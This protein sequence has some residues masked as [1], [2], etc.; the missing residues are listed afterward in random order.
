MTE[1]SEESN[2]VP[3]NNQSSMSHGPVP[4]VTGGERHPEVEDELR[5]WYALSETERFQLL[6]ESMERRRVFS[7][8]ALV[9]ICRQMF[10]SGDRKALNFAFEALSKEAT[11]LLLSQAWGLARDERHEQVQEILLH[12]FEKIQI[13]KADFAEINFAA[14]SRRKAISLYRKKKTRFEGANQ[15]IERTDEFD[16]L[17]NL[18]A[19]LP[20]PEVQALLAHSLNKLSPKHQEVFIQYHELR[21]TQKEISEHH[22]VTVR[23]VYNWL[24]SANAAIGL[25]GGNDDC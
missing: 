3:V 10:A 13:N 4:A 9:H 14:F 2:G 11:P 23:S 18:P 24:K 20:T 7:I 25:S 5:R 17:D 22:G 12:L 6:R 16:P 19:R 15:R 21:M 1:D 8:E